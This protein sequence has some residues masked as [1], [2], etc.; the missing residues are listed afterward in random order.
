MLRGSGFTVA[1]Q[2]VLALAA[3]GE[4]DRVMI[5]KGG[6]AGGHDGGERGHLLDAAKQPLTELAVQELAQDL[7]LND[8]VSDS[9]AV[10]LGDKLVEPVMDWDRVG[11][12]GRAQFAVVAPVVAQAVL[13]SIHG[14]GG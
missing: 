5:L 7:A 4:G 2:D 12:E 6:P 14:R 3:A 8:A 10:E 13:G 1:A 11:T 9:L